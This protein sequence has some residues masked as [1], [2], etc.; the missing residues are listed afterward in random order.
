VPL[1]HG[2]RTGPQLRARAALPTD[3]QA[4]ISGPLMDRIDMRVDVPAVT[5]QT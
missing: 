1:R 5:A 2:R 4:R 3:Y